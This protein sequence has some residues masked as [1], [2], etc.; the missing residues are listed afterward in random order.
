[1]P[2]EISSKQT[3]RNPAS[4]R[5]P[6]PSLPLSGPPTPTQKKRKKKK[7]FNVS[8]KLRKTHPILDDQSIHR[9]KKIWVLA[10]EFHDFGQEPT[11]GEKKD[12]S[13]DSSSPFLDEASSHPPLTHSEGD[14]E[15][16]LRNETKEQT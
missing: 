16:A 13:F 1:M 10:D 9:M 11:K 2:D 5:H 14:F 3:V 8:E 4:L 12:K 6:L 7:K 15:T